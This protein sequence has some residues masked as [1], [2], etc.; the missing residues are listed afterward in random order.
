MGDLSPK[1]G[2]CSWFWFQ[3]WG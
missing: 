3:I 2:S 1:L